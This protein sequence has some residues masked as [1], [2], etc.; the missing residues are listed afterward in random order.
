MLEVALLAGIAFVGALIFGVTG[1]GAALVTIPLATHLVPLKFALALF[2]LADLSCALRI[3]FE[4]PRK[5]LRDEWVRLVPM[6]VVGTALG[7]TLLVNLPR[8]TATL[9]LGVFILAFGLY[10]LVPH[11][12]KKVSMHWAWLAG[13]AGGITSTLF[14]AGG[15]PYAIY[16]SHRG[17]TKEQFRATMGFATLTSISL[18]A[19]AF[20]LTG[21]LLDPDV[22]WAALA[23]VPA[24]LLG[25]SAARRL[26]LKISRDTLLR[27]VSLMLLASGG[28]LVWRALG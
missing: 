19:T 17:L 5:A 21:L 24:A 20:L 10:S 13:L 11:R 15:P 9:L 8:T 1:F 12:M 4:N 7:V 2:V 26:F 27:A 28:S 22:W 25:I 23:V 6:I 18:R 3:G 14:G 16:L